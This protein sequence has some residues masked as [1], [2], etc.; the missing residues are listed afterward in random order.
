MNKYKDY[1][2]SVEA[3]QLVDIFSDYNIQTKLQLK[4]ID[5]SWDVRY[6]WKAVKSHGD[7][8]GEQYECEWNGFETVYEMLFDMVQVLPANKK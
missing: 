6:I 7:D 5:G 3:Q 2:L 1:D 4:K 8:L